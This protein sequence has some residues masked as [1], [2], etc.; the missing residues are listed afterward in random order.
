M[1]CVNIGGRSLI[2]KRRK[3]RKSETATEA[4][5]T[6][7]IRQLS[8]AIGL[9]SGSL[10]IFSALQ[11]EVT[12]ALSSPKCQSSILS[13]SPAEP[14]GGADIIWTSSK[15]G[16]LQAWDIRL[17]RLVNSWASHIG[18]GRTPY[19]AISCLS[20]VGEHTN[21]LLV[22][23][24]TI[25]LVS[26]VVYANE[27]DDQ[28][29]SSPLRELATFGGHASPVSSLRWISVFDSGKESS[30]PQVF[31]SIAE[32]DRFISLWQ[33]PSFVET[34]GDDSVMS[35]DAKEGRLI[36]SIPLD[37]DMRSISL[38]K[39]PSSLALLALSASGTLRVFPIPTSSTSPSNGQ[40][41]LQVIS[42]GSNIFTLS[43][44]PPIVSAQF[45]SA[46]RG[47]TRI[48]IARLLGGL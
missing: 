47:V 24:H 25:K 15:D 7:S 48:R 4:Q 41:S 42:G 13:I 9:Y 6:S 34:D 32:G 37:T 3:K 21:R 29:E 10:T 16:L 44:Q 30:E 20:S 2:H 22:A 17:G 27:G 18:T 31:G 39:T 5:E 33:I 45:V 8:L 1:H 38:A 46:K 12:H 26:T 35:V 23:H 19:S 40:E 36:A 28:F 43:S 11:G 14:K